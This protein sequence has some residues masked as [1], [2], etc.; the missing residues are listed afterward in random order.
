MTQTLYLDFT[1][2][3]RHDAYYL[4]YK[5]YL[6]EGGKGQEQGRGAL[7]RQGQQHVQSRKAKGR[8]REDLKALRM[9]TSRWPSQMTQS[10]G[11]WTRSTAAAMSRAAAWPRSPWL[12]LSWPKFTTHCLVSLFSG[13]KSIFWCSLSVGKPTESEIMRKDTTLSFN[14]ARIC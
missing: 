4:F 13:E 5:N 8:Q 1:F 11:F 2:M 12:L 6:Q 7:L 9:S 14:F 10:W 3:S